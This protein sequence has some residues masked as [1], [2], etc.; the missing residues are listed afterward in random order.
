MYA[1]SSVLAARAYSSATSWSISDAAQSIPAAARLLRS[2]Q[3]GCCPHGPGTFGPIALIDKPVTLIHSR[4]PS[5]WGCPRRLPASP[6]VG[7]GQAAGLGGGIRRAR[8]K[9]IGR[10]PFH[11]I[12]GGVANHEGIV[13][14]ES[15]I[16]ITVGPAAMGFQPQRARRPPQL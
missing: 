12:L 8:G 6:A 14:I 1:S 9:C 3:C 11:L 15:H 2:W 16:L 10:R 5:G 7:L 13:G 4:P